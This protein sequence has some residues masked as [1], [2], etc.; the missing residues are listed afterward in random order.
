METKKHALMKGAIMSMTILCA[1]PSFGTPSISDSPHTVDVEYFRGDSLHL[2]CDAKMR[3]DTSVGIYGRSFT[4]RKESLG[5]LGT[6]DPEHLSLIPYSKDSLAYT[7]ELEVACSDQEVNR[8]AGSEKSRR[9]GNLHC[10]ASVFAEGSK[11]VRIDRFR[12]E[13]TP[14]D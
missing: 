6:I 7:I 3:C 1:A 12:E 11:I 13:N 9:L 14:V 10:Y 5:S 8:W 2:V 4:I